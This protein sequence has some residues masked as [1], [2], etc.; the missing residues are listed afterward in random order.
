MLEFPTPYL[1]LLLRYRLF[2]INEIGVLFLDGRYLEFSNRLPCPYL[3]TCYFDV[4]RRLDA[5]EFVLM[6]PLEGRHLN[7]LETRK[8][9]RK[10]R[11]RLVSI[12]IS[13]ARTQR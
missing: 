1:S 4:K 9:D 13:R 5:V 12:N 10:G 7:Q 6:G 3:H 2:L 11:I 8:N